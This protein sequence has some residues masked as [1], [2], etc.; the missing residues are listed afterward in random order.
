MLIF[1]PAKG[2]PVELTWDLT[3][4]V[5]TKVNSLLR[6]PKKSLSTSRFM[7]SFKLQNRMYL[8]GGSR[9]PRNQFIIGKPCMQ[10]PNSRTDSIQAIV[11]YANLLHCPSISM[12]VDVFRCLIH[13]HW[14]VQQKITKDHVGF[15]TVVF[16]VELVWHLVVITEEQLLLWIIA[17]RILQW[18]Y[19]DFNVAERIVQIQ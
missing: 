18:L 13:M 2:N 14:H 16:I 17:A 15:S 9:M 12:T 4:G 5:D 6:K 3:T 11:Q 7:C 1:D 8:I 10:D 19:L